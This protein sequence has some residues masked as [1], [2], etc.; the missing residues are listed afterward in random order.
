[1]SLC[2]IPSASFSIFLI[3]LCVVH[4]F[5]SCIRQIDLTCKIFYLNNNLLLNTSSLPSQTHYVNKY[6]QSY[7]EFYSVCTPQI[8][9]SNEP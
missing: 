7:L 3:Q 9:L 5:A 6:I 2:S 1:M 4:A 8:L